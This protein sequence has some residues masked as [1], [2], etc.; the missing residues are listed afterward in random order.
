MRIL[1]LNGPNLGRLGMRQPEVYG[2]TTLAEVVAMVTDRA[3]T[4]GSTVD[5]LQTNHEG[6]LIDR[7]EQ[8]DYDAVVINPGAW[9]HT[10]Y[11]IH[12][13]LIGSERPVVE[14]HISDVRHREPFRRTSV[15]EPVVAHEIIGHGIAGYVEAVDWLHA[16]NDEAA[17]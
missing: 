13:A 12:D 9:A 16:R 8:R 17:P 3:A 15:L 1:L 4:Y 10:S 7:L 2:R 5:A 11:A 14:V 6:V